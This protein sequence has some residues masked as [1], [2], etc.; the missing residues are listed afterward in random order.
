MSSARRNT[1]A[2]AVAALALA[3][4]VGFVVYQAW[5][6]SGVSRVTTQGAGRPAP[7]HTAR[8]PSPSPSHRHP[9]SARQ[10]VIHLTAV[11][12]CWVQLTTASGHMIFSGTILAGTAKHWTEHRA[13]SERSTSLASRVSSRVPPAQ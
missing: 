13:V 1:I 7:R 8:T 11:E 12:D 6:S 4:I 5:P 3:V 2:L 9:G 10:V